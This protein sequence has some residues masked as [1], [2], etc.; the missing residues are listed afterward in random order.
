MDGWKKNFYLN[1]HFFFFINV[2]I[3]MNDYVNTLEDS[4]FQS[5]KLSSVLSRLPVVYLE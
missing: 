2:S 3:F 4:K 1:F 5:F